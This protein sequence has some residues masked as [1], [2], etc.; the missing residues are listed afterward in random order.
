MSQIIR[1]ADVCL[2]P[3]THFALT[4]AHGLRVLLSTTIANFSF[5]SRELRSALSGE[6][7]NIPFSQY[8][9]LGYHHEPDESYPHNNILYYAYN[10]DDKE[11]GR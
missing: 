7:T 8:L 5:Y 11:R 6:R 9:P 3:A 2:A 4:Y 1:Y 10:T